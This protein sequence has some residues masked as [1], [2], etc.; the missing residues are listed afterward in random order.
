MSIS[1]IQS[2]AESE[3]VFRQGIFDAT[4]HLDND[5]QSSDQEGK[6]DSPSPVL[7]KFLQDAGQESIIT[8]TGFTEIEFR[9]LYSSVQGEFTT[10]WNL[11]R[12]RKPQVKAMD[13]LLMTICVLKH[14]QNW[15]KHAL[16]FGM[17]TPTFEK[18]VHKVLLLI[19]PILKEKYIKTVSMATQR[20][21]GRTFR[22]FPYALYATD[23]RF[24]PGNRPSGRFDEQRRY[25]SEKHKLYGFKTEVSVAYPGVA[26]LVSGHVQG[27]VHDFTLFSSRIEVH[28]RYLCK[29][30][31][32]LLIEDNGNYLSITMN[33][34]LFY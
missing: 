3:I 23:V 33:H 16:D 32:E 11:G 30:A 29:S 2:L 28:R 9:L 25:Y 27:S 14:Y 1:I 31:E 8:L 26:V 13:A 15:D 6:Y 10:K 21:G 4:N 20:Q 5:E 18:M 22:N 17:K 24:Q 7:D 12:G 19:E 34:G